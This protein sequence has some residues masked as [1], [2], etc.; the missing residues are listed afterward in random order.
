MNTKSIRPILFGV[1][2]IL[3]V[4][5]A[6]AS[7]AYGSINNFDTVNDTGHEC[8][9]FEIE[10]EDCHS[11]DIT[12]TYN[13]NHYGVPNITEE[14]SIPAHPRCIIR[15]ESKKAPD[16]S[17]AAYT[18]IPGG[19]IAPTNGHMFTNPNVNFGGEH[20]G[21][22]YRV[23]V[24][25]V[26]YSWLIDNGVGQL[27]S[28]GPVQVSTPAFTYNAGQ[29]QAVIP[30]PEP[31]EIHVKEFGPA[32]WVKEIRTESH[33][34]RKVALRDLVSDDPDDDDDRNW[35][36]GEPDEVEVEWQLLQEEFAAD[37]GGGNGHLEAAPEAL[38]NGDEVVTR[39]YEFYEYTGPY[40]NENG[41]AKAENVGPDGIHGRGVKEINGVEIDLATVEVVGE[42]KGA[43]MAA[44]DV[45]AA[46][47]LIEHVSEGT[48]GTPY[49][50]RRIVVEGILPF[51]CER[52]GDLPS[53]MTFDEVTGILEGTPSQSGEFHFKVTARDGLKP[54]VARNYTLLVAPAGEELPPA[55]LVDTS[56]LPAG[57][58]TSTGDGAYAP[59][60]DVTVIATAAPGYQFA[61]W[62]DNGQVVS[63][64]AT[65]TFPI[66]V[67]HSLVA[68]FVAALPS[69]TINI[70]PSPAPDGTFTIEWPL[71][72]PGWM[73]EESPD[74]SPGSWTPSQRPITVEGPMQRVT[75][76]PLAAPKRYF[77]LS[78]P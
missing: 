19:P 36:N 41:E 10:I 24:G 66:D 64:S 59:G 61:H 11:T 38:E 48:E 49:V 27:I 26:H 15:W 20:F 2:T 3:A 72:P 9:G 30:A 25:A 12:Y 8:H 57:S 70:V 63:T 23:A 13:Y 53:G 46:L 31:P 16:G 52:T 55:S 37:D 1:F 4:R 76:D 39:R 51:T 69:T 14:N 50:A 7:I 35:R 29:V 60:D 17:W 74:L 40:D 5:D 45:E 42:Y 68:Q 34:K 28:G 71:D 21:V 43:Q 62:T 32:V 18:A 78:H 44:V 56:V 33:N 54:E 22:G 58:G 77:H 47:G 67:N 65:Y 6:E 75:V 73:L